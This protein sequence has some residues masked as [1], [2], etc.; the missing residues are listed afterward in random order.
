LQNPLLKKDFASLRVQKN[1]S[2]YYTDN[3]GNVNV[4]G[5]GNATFSLEGLFAEVQTN[6]NT[7]SFTSNLSNTNVTF[8]NSNSTIQ[9]RTAFYAV[10][11]IH[12]HLKSVF[13]TFT[14]LDSLEHQY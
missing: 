5:I 3:L 4:P 14:G 10:N 1:G 9:E 8:D 12:D 13:P 6:N 2:N 11:Q 7:P